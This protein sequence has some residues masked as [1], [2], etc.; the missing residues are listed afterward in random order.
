MKAKLTQVTGMV[1]CHTHSCGIDVNNYINLRYPCTQDAN[2]LS[3]L[4]QTNGID[5]SLT[6][7]M[8][9]SLY[10][11]SKKYW[12]EKIY[13]PS[14]LEDIPFCIENNY[15]LS[16]LEFFDLNHILP[17]VSISLQDKV[18]EQCDFIKS[19]L[20]K[21]NIYGIKHHTKADQ[22]GISD[23]ETS[24][25]PI[26]ELAEEY[27]LP[28]M[29]HTERNGISSPMAIFDIA[30]KHPK[31]RFCLAHYAGFSK[32]FFQELDQYKTSYN[33]VFFD[34]A[35]S[36]F[37]I[38][39]IVLSDDVLDISFKHP[40]DVV[41]YFLTHYNDCFLWGTDSPWNCAY[42]LNGSASTI[43]KYND[44]LLLREKAESKYSAYSIEAVNRFLFG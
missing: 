33:N 10:Y 11:D 42:P 40:V 30:S 35:P 4:M 15:L 8:P 2:I 41:G 38:N 26:L 34:S 24:G 13:C 32:S 1:D 28:I 39:N 5:F 22:K 7:P 16:E 21:H 37:L 14:G 18:K 6:F 25:K 12:T 19:L 20:L 44:E 43:Y 27:N 36:L 23:Y 9:S 3:E 31:L 29:V 17:F